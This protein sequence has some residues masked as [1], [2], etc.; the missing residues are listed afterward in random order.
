[1]P[2]IAAGAFR[3]ALR[4]SIPLGSVI[5]SLT[6]L[7]GFIRKEPYGNQ[8]LFMRRNV[9][10]AVGGFVNWPIL[11]DVDMVKRLRRVGR[12]CITSETAPTSA[13]RWQQGGVLGT[14][15]RGC[16]HCR[17]P[18]GCARP[19]AGPSRRDAPASRR[20][21]RA[22]RRVEDES[23]AEV[24]VGQVGVGGDGLIKEVAAPPRSVRPS[25]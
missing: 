20:P 16:A 8:G 10:Q 21:T 6:R 19:E 24:G 22:V 11:E 12:I 17:K 23:L 9:F 18:R 13:R 1:M 14:S 3:F 4:E 7:R 2:G 5:E 25:G 15:R